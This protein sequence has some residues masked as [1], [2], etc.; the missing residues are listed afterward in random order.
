VKLAFVILGEVILGMILGY[1]LVFYTPL[2]SL[3]NDNSSP[4]RVVGKAPNIVFGFLPYWLAGKETSDYTKYIT[5][6]AYF[7]LTVN[8]DG[9]IRKMDNE[10]EEEPGWHALR[11]GAMDSHFKKAR[12]HG[13]ALSLVLFNA[14]P[15]EIDSLMED[16][17][18]HAK[19]LMGDV[20]PLMHQYGFT[21][22]N[23]DI[24]NVRLASDES[25]VHFTQFV[26]EVKKHLDTKKGETLSLDLTASDFIKKDLIDP[27]AI[28]P[29]VDHMIIMA[30]DYHYAGSSVTGPV[31]PLFGAGRTLEYDVDRAVQKALQVTPSE[32]II[33]GA[34]LYGYEWETISDTPHAGIIPGTGVVAT[35]KRIEGLAKSCATCSA[36]FDNES[37]EA[38]IIYKD[39]I[40]TYHQIFY[41]DAS[42][43]KAKIDFALREKLGGLALWALGYEDSKILSPLSMYKK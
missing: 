40:G 6:L 20:V 21:D 36:Q 16:S 10:L 19:N 24:E 26:T 33:V 1:I 2:F 29:L 42:S 35:A 34:P 8:P 22:L 12:K 17:V 30:Y 14:D 27:R 28:G 41:P 31:A 3:Q 13:I 18:V 37:K 7:S 25:R 4:L 9:T 11:G 23:L 39:D 38:Y 5:N 43:M 32:K 15:D